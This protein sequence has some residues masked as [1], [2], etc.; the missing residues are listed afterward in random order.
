M[1][2]TIQ[3]LTGQDSNNNRRPINIGVL[4][5]GN[6]GHDN[7]AIRSTTLGNLAPLIQEHPEL[8]WQSLQVGDQ[9][10][11]KSYEAEHENLQLSPMPE[12]S[13]FL[14]T[15]HLIYELDLVIC[16]DTAVAHLAATLGIATWILI[17]TEP[18][19]RWGQQGSTTP[20]YPCVRLFRQKNLGDWQPVVT[21]INQALS[22]LA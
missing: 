8:N 10:F 16:V 2:T 12:V 4:W 19:W 9:D 20:W 7:D 22:E 21:E 11:L 5:A 6:P 1:E 3:S 15:A 14:D 18:D 17:A 13:D